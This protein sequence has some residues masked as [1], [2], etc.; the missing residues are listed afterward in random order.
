[1]KK[2]M[3]LLSALL[4]IGAVA[5]AQPADGHKAHQG[6]HL[7]TARAE[8]IGFITERLA[9]TPEEAQVFWPVYNAYEQ[10]VMEAGK[11]VRTARKA[12]RPAKDAAEPTEKEVKARIEDYL[13]ALK[14]EAEVK[15]KYNSQFLKVLPAAK[16]AKLYLAEE[17]FQNKMLREMYKRQAEHHGQPGLRP[18]GKGPR[19]PKDGKPGKK[20]PADEKPVTPPETVSD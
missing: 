6:K 11:A 17:S 9:L 15:A 3:V 4:V 20:E 13:K 14:A 8:K 18:D 1:M 19:N 10:E 16:V 7:E 2:I 5:Y 12:L